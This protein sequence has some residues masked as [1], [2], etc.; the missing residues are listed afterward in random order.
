MLNADSFLS[1]KPK[2][3]DIP[4]EELGGEIRV[5]EMSAAT[6]ME[7]SAKSTEN[8]DSTLFAIQHSVVDEN[9]SPLFN[10]ETVQTLSTLPS[11]LVEKIVDGI[12]EVNG[13]KK[14]E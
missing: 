11:R 7:W 14:T 9:G 5:Q 6:L 13:L 3:L 1:Y 2:T 10:D 12:M 4:I 8:L